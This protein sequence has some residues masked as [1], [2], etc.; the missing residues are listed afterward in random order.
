ME[1]EQWPALCEMAM[2]GRIDE[3][4][5]L[6]A[7]GVDVNCNF[8]IGKTPLHLAM[9]SK[10]GAQQGGQEEMVRVLL[11]ARADPSLKDSQG[12]TPRLSPHSHTV[13]SPQGEVPL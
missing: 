1:A 6:L 11:D 5:R 3:V 4:R 13:C 2:R 9:T 10:Y 8:R 7:D 12:S